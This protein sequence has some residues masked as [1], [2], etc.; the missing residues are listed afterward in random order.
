[1]DITDVTS[2]LHYAGFSGHCQSGGTTKKKITKL[3][4]ELLEDNIISYKFVET[5]SHEQE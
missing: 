2:E 5:K 1:M 4:S 3:R